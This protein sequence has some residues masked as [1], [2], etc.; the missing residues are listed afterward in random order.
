M[1]GSMSYMKC[2]EVLKILISEGTALLARHGEDATAAA[3]GG[4]EFAFCVLAHFSGLKVYF[5]KFTT[6]AARKRLSVISDDVQENRQSAAE[7]VRKYGITLTLA[8]QIIKKTQDLAANCQD[9]H[10]V[11][12]GIAI[13][14]AR[15]LIKHGVAPSD[16]V[17]AA[18]GFSGVIVAR[19]SGQVLSFPSLQTIKAQ[20]RF[21]DIARQYHNGAKCNEIAR[22][23]G[24]SFVQVYNIVREHCKKNGIEPPRRKQQKNALHTLKSRILDA[25]KPYR[26]KDTEICK[27]LE[28]AADT[29]GQVMKRLSA[30]SK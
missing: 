3:V 16:A 12:K 14:A 5:P 6:D 15:M 21:D 23:Y 17:I 10:Y 8:Y 24:L 29:L 22:R 11:V 20:K 18:R 27:L 28:S 2:G 1:A 9:A 30:G 7:I 26:E 19:F 25:A 13:E 4:E